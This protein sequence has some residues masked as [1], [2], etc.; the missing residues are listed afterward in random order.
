MIR[1]MIVKVCPLFDRTHLSKKAK[2]RPA[3]I[4]ED[5]MEQPHK[6]NDLLTT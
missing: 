6:N 1:I 3:R 4:Y 2:T 5:F